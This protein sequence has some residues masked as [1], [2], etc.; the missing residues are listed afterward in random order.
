MSQFFQ[1]IE[2]TLTL[3][4]YSVR[5][6]FKHKQL[7]IVPIVR[8]VAVILTAAVAWGLGGLLVYAFK[9]SEGINIIDK[10]AISAS[11]TVL[12]IVCVFIFMLLVSIVAMLAD[13]TLTHA[14]GDVFRKGRVSLLDAFIKSFRHFGRTVIW[15]TTHTLV[16][17]I[18]SRDSKSIF[19]NILGDLFI[20]GWN[21]ATLFIVPVFAFEDLGVYASIKE[22]A[23]IFEN[24]FGKAAV[25]E[26]SFSRL[27][28]LLMLTPLALLPVVFYLNIVPLFFIVYLLF[29]ILVIAFIALAD[30]IF[31][32]ALYF[33]VKGE[34]TGE[35][36]TRVLERS[37]AKKE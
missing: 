27:S 6:A 11:D 21:L 25:A 4:G 20:L 32:T 37:F 10:H 15:A 5:Y 14:I 31:T 16:H 34:P 1:T 13:L 23:G 29:I 18:A 26:F 22:S 28:L 9:G 12:I 7:L 36:D 2:N 35:I 24:H 8:F 3:V 17:L 33:Y 30:A 19:G